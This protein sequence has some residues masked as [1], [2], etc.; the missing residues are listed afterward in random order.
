MDGGRAL[1]YV[2]S[3]HAEGNEGS[4]FARSRRQQDVIVALKQ[5][6]VTPTLIFSPK[7]FIALFHAFD[8]AVDSDMN[9]GELATVGKGLMKT[10]EDAVKRISLE[11]F[12]EAPPLWLY[13]RYVLVP[14]KDFPIV[15][16]FIQEQLKQ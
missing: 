5:K 8:R 2:R 10:K 16:E 14:I 6:L 12:L 4:D 15:H 13:G 9:I 3:R 11:P 7:K 1:Q